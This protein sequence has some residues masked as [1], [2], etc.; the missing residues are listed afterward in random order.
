MPQTALRV[1][2][3]QSG[4]AHCAWCDT[5]I[6]EGTPRIARAFHHAAGAFSRN[7]GAATGYNPGGLQ[8]MF[9]HVQCAL[10]YDDNPRGSPAACAGGC[11]MHC[12]PLRRMLSRFGSAGARCIPSSSAPL[13]YCFPCAKAFVRRHR[14]LLVGH[15]S[16]RQAQLNVGWVGWGYAG[17]FPAPGQGNVGGPPPLPKDKALLEAFLD[18]FRFDPPQT[19]AE[20][21]S[22]CDRHESLQLSIR[23]ALAKDRSRAKAEA[24]AP[25]TAPPHSRR[26]TG[27]RPRG[28]WVVG[29]RPRSVRRCE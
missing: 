4:R 16:V 3:D 14:E 5:G 1:E 25:K 24:T 18:C 6:A 29:E 21:E 23:A 20:E 19:A 12:A 13:Y 8:D 2:R 15:I 28:V 26:H 10:R 17:L 11:G 27:K 22:A 9:M 7:N